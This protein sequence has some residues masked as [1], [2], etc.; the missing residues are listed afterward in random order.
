MNTLFQIENFKPFQELHLDKPYYFGFYAIRVKDITSLSEI[1][2]EE[3]IA[4]QS[5]LIYIGISEKQTL[6]KRICQECFG[7][8]HGTFF[9][10][11]GTLLGY[12]PPKGSAHTP[13]SAKNYR[14]E[15]KD[16]ENIKNWIFNNLI[17]SFV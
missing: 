13:K 6:Y 7:V 14:F 2:K 10:G 11:I 5:T 16:I 9:R 3:T 15:K 17:I 4:C 8:G 12:M 1:L